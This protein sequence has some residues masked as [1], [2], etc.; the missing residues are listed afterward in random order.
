M[1]DTLKS[2]PCPL[3][4]ES[5]S[6][7]F[8][9][10]P[11]G[12]HEVEY[13]IC[14]NCGF[15]FQSHAPSAKELDE[16]YSDQYRQP[17]IVNGKPAKR[18][19]FREQAR[20]KL[21]GKFLKKHKVNQIKSALDIGSSTGSLL[22]E[23]QAQFHAKVIG[24]EPGDTYRKYAS[25]R[26]LEVY[27]SMEILGRKS[28]SKFDLITM[29]HVL[30]H[31]ENPL[32]F[33]KNLRKNWLASQGALLI[34]VP[35]TYSHDSFEFPHVSAF[36]PHSLHEILKQSGYGVEIFY[37]HGRPLSKVFPLY[38]LALAR[39]MQEIK[40]KG[41]VHRERLVV[42]KRAFGMLLRRVIQKLVPSLAWLPNK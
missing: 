11:L 39:P 17:D 29:M 25:I 26:K 27:P 24:V 1:K 10:L 14:K 31:L 3:C 23:M 33:L 38:L 28:T 21:I 6:Q 22:K 40:A 12:K 42:E 30:E 5:Y 4:G 9:K 16:F 15:I 18:V 32:E 13:V 19:L 41:K 8:H 36:T 37:K 2:K 7:I 20:A 35:N 34:E